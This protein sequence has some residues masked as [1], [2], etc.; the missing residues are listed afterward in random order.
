MSDLPISYSSEEINGWLLWQLQGRLDRLTA[1]A[2]AA[3]GEELLAD[4]QKLALDLSALSYLSSAGIRIIL[5]LADGAKQV[6]KPFAVVSA[7][8]MVKEILEM[9]RLDMFVDIYPSAEEL[10]NA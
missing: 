1:E 5:K 3:K 8:G 4:C 6:E 7:E 9:A 10:E 2:V